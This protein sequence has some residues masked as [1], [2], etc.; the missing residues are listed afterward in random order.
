MEP[1]QNGAQLLRLGGGHR[2]GKEGDLAVLRQPGN[3]RLRD[4]GVHHHQLGVVQQGGPGAEKGRGHVVVDLHVRHRQLHVPLRPGDVEVGGGGS[5]GDLQS[6]ADVD[7]QLAAGG[8]HPLG[9]HVV[10]KGGEQVD[11]RPQQGQVVGDVPPHAPQAHP[12]PAGVG[13]PGDQRAG[14]ATPDVHVHAPHHHGVG[15]CA[16]DVALPGD[17]SLFHQVGDVHRRRGPGDPR[18]VCQ[19]LLGDHGVLLNP[20]QELPFPLGHGVA[21]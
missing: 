2:I 4:V 12:H 11:L 19:L 18:L 1:P 6:V 9:L 14:G 13:V 20:A 17:M 15:R 10:A 3:G 16:Q 7:A 8:G 5:A 21:S